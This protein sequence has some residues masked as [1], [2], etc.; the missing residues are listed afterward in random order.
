MPATVYLVSGANR[1]IGLGFVKE[2][3]KRENVIVF[4]G[5]RD[6]ARATDLKELASTSPRKLHI[7]KLVSADEA[8][9]RAAIEEVKSIAGRLD[10]VIANAAIATFSGPVIQTPASEM[11]EH[12]NVNV[13]GPLVLF[14]ASYPLLKA[15]TSTPKF[16]VISSRLGSITLAPNMPSE[17]T[18]YGASK[19]AVNYLTR[20]LHREH[21][22]LIVFPICPGP[23]DT[24]AIA[25]RKNDEHLKGLEILSVDQVI[26]GLLSTIDNATRPKDGPPFPTIEGTVAPW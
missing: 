17:M 14:Q 6:P 9:N 8:G 15:S 13:V 12:Y 11:L 25:P 1:G 20:K 26:P 23:V 18:P 5:V 10:V 3:L 21:D 2:L 4:T 22:D 19:A 16:I 24:D 7:V